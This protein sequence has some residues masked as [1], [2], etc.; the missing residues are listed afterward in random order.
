M[1]SQGADLLAFAGL[2]RGYLDARVLDLGCGAGHVAFNVAPH[3]AEVVA[4]DLSAEMLEVVKTSAIERGLG[5]IVPRQ[6]TAESLPFEDGSF[7]FVV[8]RYSAHHWSDF[9]A[10]LRE[11]ARVLKPGGT[12]AFVDAISPGLPLLDTFIQSL[13]VLRDPSHVRNYSRSEWEAALVRAGLV[14]GAVAA[15]R[16]RLEFT[17]WVERMRSPPV[18]I[19]AIRALQDTISASVRHHFQIGSDGSFDLDVAFFQASKPSQS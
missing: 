17:S 10:G 14:P 16:I 5:N 15:Y 19:A 1:H 7:D 12:T 3:A 4:Y 8:S 11:A 2:V 9:D 18:M 13:E 6:G